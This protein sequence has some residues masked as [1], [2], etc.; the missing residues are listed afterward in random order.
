MLSFAQFLITVKIIR[1]DQITVSPQNMGRSSTQQKSQFLESSIHSSVPHELKYF[2][3]GNSN[4]NENQN[5]IMIL[6]FKA[7]RFFH[8]KHEIN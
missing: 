4:A 7:I 3:N 2:Q 5:L 1:D 8:F 6:L